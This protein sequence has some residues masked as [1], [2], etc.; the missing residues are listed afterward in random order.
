LPSG[1][2]AGEPLADGASPFNGYDRNGPT[3]VIK[4]LCKYN[5]SSSSCGTLL[6]MKFSPQM[7]QSKRGRENFINM[8]KTENSL[9]GYHVQF[10]IVNNETLKKAQENP[11]EYSDL[12][13][14]VAGYSAFFVDLHKEVQDA[15][16]SRTENTNW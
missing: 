16:I 5:P 8:L 15:I 6:N 2:K 4:S 14:R 1:R 9:G 11:R 13:V 12:M 10:N 7:L 3:A